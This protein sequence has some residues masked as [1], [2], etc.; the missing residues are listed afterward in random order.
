MVN[1][2]SGFIVVKYTLKKF[3]KKHGVLIKSKLMFDI[4]ETDPDV[5]EYD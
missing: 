4:D 3:D 5:F 2:I 1:F